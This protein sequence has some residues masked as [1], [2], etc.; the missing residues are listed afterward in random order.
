VIVIHVTCHARSFHLK[1]RKS[2]GEADESH[3]LPSYA[4]PQ[5]P[6]R[7]RILIR[8]ESQ[9]TNSCR[10]NRNIKVLSGVRK[11]D[12]S[13]SLSDPRAGLGVCFVCRKIQQ[14][15]ALIRGWVEDHVNG[16]YLG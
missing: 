5:A 7:P 14:R 10:D 1:S 6:L 12:M 16:K 3:T 13:C 2:G 11:Y 9:I 4:F 8:L 15:R